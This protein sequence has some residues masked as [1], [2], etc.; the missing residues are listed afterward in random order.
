MDRRVDGLALIQ[1]DQMHHF[2]D[3]G[4]DYVWLC[5]G[6]EYRDTPRGRLVRI[7]NLDG[8][9]AAIGRWIVRNPM[10]LRG[11]EVRFLRS[12]MKLSQ[13]GL[14]DLLGQSRA[15]VARWE[16]E[17]NK[18]IP[19]GTD[20][21]LRVVYTKTADGDAELSR[22]VSLLMNLDELTHGPKAS[23]SASFAEKAESWK[24]APCPC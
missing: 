4:L 20:H 17:P 19:P 5:N 18:V 1:G 12:M 9:H 6:F 3:C 8:L 7:H 22:I 11:Q 15:S 23:R 2:T 14:A 16:G 10:R 21:W 13:A 24:A